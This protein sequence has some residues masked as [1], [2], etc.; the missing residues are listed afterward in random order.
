V[1]FF[2]RSSIKLRVSVISTDNEFEIIW[3][4]V[5]ADGTTS[6]TYVCNVY[7][8]GENYSIMNRQAFF[9]ALSEQCLRLST[10]GDIILLGDFNV[11][12]GDL[13][14]ILFQTRR[15]LFS[16]NFCNLHL[17]TDGHYP[18]VLNT[19]SAAF[20]CSTRQE[21]T[22]KLIIDYFIVASSTLA[23]VIS[24]HVANEDEMR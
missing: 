17:R 19:S 8:P 10:K 2:I 7:A 11:R 4:K 14:G 22:S 24:F 13:T 23:R 16:R 1:G 20:G 5:V 12:L 18:N 15:P 3:L 21:G 6:D 9:N